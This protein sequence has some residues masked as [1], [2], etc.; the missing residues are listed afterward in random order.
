M[1]KIQFLVFA[2]L[3]LAWC[4]PV[5]M[6]AQNSQLKNLMDGTRWTDGSTFYHA[7]VK[8][9]FVNLS[10]GTMH[11]GGYAFG[12]KC[13]DGKGQQ[14]TLQNGHWFPDEEGE[15]AISF[16]GQVGQK[17][18]M[19]QSDG[20][21]YLLVMDNSGAPYYSFCQMSE[22]ENLGMVIARM[23]RHSYEGCYRV[24][25]ST[26]T[27]VKKND[28]CSFYLDHVVLGDVANCAYEFGEEFESPT[29]VLRLENGMSL[30]VKFTQNPASL[31]GGLKLYATTY[32]KESDMYD[33]GKLLLVLYRESEELVTK[34]GR[35]TESSE[36]ILLPGEVTLY[37]RPMLRLMRN[38]I[39]ARHGY[40]FSSKD[41]QQYF[42]A[43]DW[44]QLAPDASYNKKFKPSA[45]ESANIN[46][47]KNIENSPHVWLPDFD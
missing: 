18:E 34:P 23:M 16:D 12:L 3:L 17:V 40:V 6:W 20:K 28:V 4:L 41:L 8:G 5:Q 26:M 47:I 19:R 46:I 21:N 37:P 30:R 1:K 9:D 38:E 11:E 27:G 42:G 32:N 31:Q 25:R 24:A 36:R 7:E 22:D 15:G 43:Q 45:T 14:F 13:T 33:D 44:Y 2:A 39:F 10:G 29:D 35:W